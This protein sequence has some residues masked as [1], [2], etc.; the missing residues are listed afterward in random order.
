MIIYVCKRDHTYT[1]NE[2]YLNYWRPDLRKIIRIETYESLF[3]ARR[4]PL[5]TYIFSDIERL[6]P[7]EQEAVAA[8]YAALEAHDPA[9]LRLNHPLAS[10]RRFGLL[11]TLAQAGLNDFAIYRAGD[12]PR[13]LRFPVFV[14]GDHDHDGPI[15]PLLNDQAA[16]D[17]WLADFQSQGRSLDGYVVIEFLETRT[18][19][20]TFVK[21]GA[22]CVNG[23]IL[24][25]HVLFN[26]EWVVKFGDGRETAPDR[27]A[28]ELDYAHNQPH[29]QQIKAIFKRAAIEYG[30]IDYAVVNDRVQTFEINTNPS[31]IPFCEIENDPR[32]PN[33]HQF[34]SAFT[35]A[36]LAIDAPLRG[37][38]KVEP[39]DKPIYN[40]AREVYRTYGRRA[41]WFTAREAVKNFVRRGPRS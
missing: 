30:R 11:Q 7:A 1:L 24:P 36:L 16:L 21:Y 23:T 15:S 27:V 14:R 41:G 29:K 6:E 8:L 3:Q 25:Q 10:K 12:D 31:V 5:C 38:A 26:S 39:T 35:D 17:A 18:D 22:Y 9:G 40:A 4:I 34:V 28:F 19:G 37:Y 2:E 33:R 13:P 32:S 20:K